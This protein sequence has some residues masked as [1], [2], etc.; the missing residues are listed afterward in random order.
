MFTPSTPQRRRAKS[1]SPVTPTK[2]DLKAYNKI[3]T[4]MKTNRNT[5]PKIY[6]VGVGLGLAAV[7]YGGHAGA[8]DRAKEQVPQV[9]RALDRGNYEK[10]A[11]LHEFVEAKQGLSGN[12]LLG[13]RII[14]GLSL[15][16][17]G[18]VLIGEA[19]ASSRRRSK[20]RQQATLRAARLAQV[21][22]AQLEQ[23]A[24]AAQQAAAE[25]SVLDYG[26][27]EAARTPEII[28]QG[29]G[30][31]EDYLASKVVIEHD[32]AGNEARPLQAV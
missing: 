19:Q 20:Q 23:A 32:V 13:A 22:T 16:A 28:L 26:D 10:A 5:A 15:A 9:E 14:G 3:I 8:E 7:L 30:G 31:H 4:V 24:Q 1:A 2:L 29:Y 6:A 17:G 12:L 25:Q 21:R 27:S 11:N 18:M